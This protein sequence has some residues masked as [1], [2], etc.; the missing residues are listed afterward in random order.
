MLGR[1]VRP[2]RNNVTYHPGAGFPAPG[3][4][5]LETYE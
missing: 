1:S 3:A 4:I 5:F 2:W